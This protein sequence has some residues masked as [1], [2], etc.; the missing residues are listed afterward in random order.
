MMKPDD[1]ITLVTVFTAIVSVLVCIE[2]MK[3]GMEEE[4]K[5]KIMKK[6]KVHVRWN[7]KGYTKKCKLFQPYLNLKMSLV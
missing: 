5:D 7:T 3:D 2:W 4:I 1:L 6:N